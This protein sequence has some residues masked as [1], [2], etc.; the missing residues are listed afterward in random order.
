MPSI[1]MDVAEIHVMKKQHQ[2]KMEMKKRDEIEK[3][4]EKKHSIW[5]TILRHFK[6]VHL[7]CLTT[8][9]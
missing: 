8:P 7:K 4:S 6:K 5:D 2:E 9:K 1:G 3:V